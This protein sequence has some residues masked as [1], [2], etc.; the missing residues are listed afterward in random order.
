MKNLDLKSIS[1]II[2]IC[3][4]IASLGYEWGTVKNIE[5]QTHSNTLLIAEDRK[6][7]DRKYEKINDKLNQII[8]AIHKR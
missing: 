2:S 6:E 8:E 1:L 3:V 7:A 4:A 5:K